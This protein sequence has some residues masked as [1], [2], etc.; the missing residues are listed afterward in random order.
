MTLLSQLMQNPR[1][2]VHIVKDDAVGNEVV[3][4]DAFPLFRALMRGDDPLTAKEE[5][6]DQAI[7]GL[8]FVHRG[9]NRLA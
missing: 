7:E 9:L 8:A 6:L 2:C 5:S 3:V 4:F 1:L